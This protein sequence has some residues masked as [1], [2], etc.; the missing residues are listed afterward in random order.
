M[1]EVC[2][3][4]HRT[5]VNYCEQGRILS[6]KSPVTSYRRIPRAGLIT[7]MARY[8]I[9][10]SALD[11]Y[12]SKS[13]LIADDDPQATDLL[14]N[15]ILECFE[16]VEITVVS[17]GYDALIEAGAGK[18]DLLVLD[19][20]MPR[21]DGLEVC[22]NLKQARATR[23]IPILVVTGLADLDI[24]AKARANGADAVLLKPVDLEEFVKQVARLAKL[25]PAIEL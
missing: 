23:S 8:G 3:I 7:F 19:I 4:S 22:R 2:G 10:E 20:A 24:P 21:I 1:A 12:Q 13:V 5:V 15:M 25:E 18:P 6:T 14:R 17:N 11:K 9:P 16:N